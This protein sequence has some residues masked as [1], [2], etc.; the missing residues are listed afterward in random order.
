MRLPRSIPMIVRRL[1]ASNVIRTITNTVVSSFE[2][3]G[4][5]LAS[6]IYDTTRSN[7]AISSILTRI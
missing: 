3:G 7:C 5:N 1:R 2:G 6:T 4:G